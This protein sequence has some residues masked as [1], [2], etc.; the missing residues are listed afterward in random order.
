MLDVERKIERLG[1]SSEVSIEPV[2]VSASGV[3]SAVK[4]DGFFSQVIELAE[5]VDRR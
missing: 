1:V 2:L 5:L 4:R 3:T